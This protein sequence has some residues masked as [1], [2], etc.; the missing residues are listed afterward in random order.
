M[1]L[2]AMAL[3]I[4]IYENGQQAELLFQI[5]D[6]LYNSLS[7]VFDLYKS[8][9]GIFIDPYRDTIFS[10]GLIQLIQACRDSF[11]EIPEHNRR[12]ITGFLSQLEAWESA[13]YA[14][15]FVGD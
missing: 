14:I 12:Y 5:D 6:R 9:T 1:G 2:S 10:N 13:D 11:P 7:P 3:D 4:H 15:I 8:R